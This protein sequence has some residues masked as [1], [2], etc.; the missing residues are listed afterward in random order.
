MYS[1]AAMY[2][3]ASVTLCALIVTSL[4]AGSPIQDRAASEI[5]VLEEL[6]TGLYIVEL[7]YQVQR[8]HLQAQGS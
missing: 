2:K 6:S 8:I 3:S 7:F 1:A 4:V 5:A